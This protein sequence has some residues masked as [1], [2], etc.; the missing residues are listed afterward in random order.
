M[1]AAAVQVVAPVGGSWGAEDSVPQPG[2]FVGMGLMFWAAAIWT[3][4]CGRSG[5]GV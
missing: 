5:R 1:D 3:A 4:C 2:N